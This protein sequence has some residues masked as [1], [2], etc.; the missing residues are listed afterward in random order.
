MSRSIPT[1]DDYLA[2]D[3]ITVMPG[4]DIHMAAD[5]FMNSAFRRFPILKNGRMTGQIS[6]AGLLRALEEH[7]ANGQPNSR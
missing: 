6:R 5:I 1:V 4:D 3:L 2:R 7:W